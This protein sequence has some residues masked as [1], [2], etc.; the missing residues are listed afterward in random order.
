MNNNIPFRYYRINVTVAQFQFSVRGAKGQTV[1]LV[2]FTRIHYEVW[3]SYYKIKY[4][5][6]Y[7]QSL[8]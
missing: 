6:I 4:I 1:K 8:K 2:F 7:Y 3:I 5:K